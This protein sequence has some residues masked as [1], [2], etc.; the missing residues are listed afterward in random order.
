MRNSFKPNSRFGFLIDEIDKLPTVKLDDNKKS[1]P[2]P[3]SSSLPPSNKKENTFKNS[4]TS[5]KNEIIITMDSFPELISSKQTTTS[6]QTN[7]GYADKLKIEVEKTVEPNDS[8]EPDLEPGW[9]ILKRENGKT[10]IKRN[11]LDDAKERENE[12]TREVIDALVSLHEKRTQEYIDSYG[13]D[14]WEKTFKYPNW[15]A[16]IAFFDE[17]SEEEG[18]D[19][20]EDELEDEYY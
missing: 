13:Y 8:S 12:W 3:P 15:E 14:S 11:L 17:D 5:R 20:E 18:E 16:D 1:V 7:T 10:V 2:L 19:L 6:V 4:K 9:V